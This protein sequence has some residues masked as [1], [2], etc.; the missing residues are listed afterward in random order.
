M[1]ICV[2]FTYVNHI[3]FRILRPSISLS[4]LVCV[5][6]GFGKW[7]SVC[8]HVSTVRLQ[9][10]LWTHDLIS[11]I[12]IVNISP[13]DLILRK[14]YHVSFVPLPRFKHNSHQGFD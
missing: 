10:V 14:L 11:Q 8:I 4:Q 2:F 12:I 6:V 13:M 7:F 5:C 3:T 9:E 1:L